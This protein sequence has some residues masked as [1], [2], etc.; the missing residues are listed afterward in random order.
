MTSN[1]TTQTRNAVRLLALI[2]ML[3]P[4]SLVSTAQTHTGVFRPPAGNTEYH[5]FN[6]TGVGAA[7]YINQ[8][9][10][11]YPILRLSR[12]TATANENVVSTLHRNF[13]TGWSV[14]A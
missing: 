14:K 1:K 2:G 3:A 5:Q 11:A 10:T 12:C 9:H 8:V 13:L 6:R 4:L 7:V